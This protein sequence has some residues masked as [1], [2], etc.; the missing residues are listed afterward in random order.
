MYQTTMFSAL[1]D[2]SNV[3]SNISYL[4]DQIDVWSFVNNYRNSSVELRLRYEDQIDELNV[5][6]QNTLDQ[7]LPTEGVEY[8]LYSTADDEYLTEWEELDP[9]NKTV[10]FGFYSE[11]IP[12]IPEPFDAAEYMV[13]FWAFLI[14]F[15][16]AIVIMALYVRFRQD[17]KEIPEEVKERY[18][19]R[20]N[21][22]FDNRFK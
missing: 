8:A 13:V 6:A 18:K 15:V 17:T 2:W 16:V 9:D 1:L 4:E 22:S 19:K 3:G 21:T 12:V 20:Q 5:A 7:W 14:V 10:T 11:E